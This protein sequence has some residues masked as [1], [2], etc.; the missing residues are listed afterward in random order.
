MWI[1]RLLKKLYNYYGSNR[2]E[3]LTCVVTEPFFFPNE[4]EELGDVLFGY[5]IYCG[6]LW[7]L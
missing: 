6:A 3:W 4:Y 5:C 7:R 2:C 1:Q